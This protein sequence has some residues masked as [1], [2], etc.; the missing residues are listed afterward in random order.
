MRILVVVPPSQQAIDQANQMSGLFTGHEIQVAVTA[1]EQNRHLS[2]ADILLSNAFVPVTAEDLRGAKNLRFIQVLGVGVDHVDLAAAKAHGIV[3]ADVA[4]AN[5]TSVAEH[6]ILSLLCLYRPILSSHMAIQ[7]GQWPLAQWLNQAEDLTG[8]TI[9]IV[10]MGR[11]GRELARRLIPFAVGLVYNDV[12]RLP[13]E[14]ESELG[15][16]YVDKSDLLAISDAVTLHLP[17]TK[18]THHFMDREAF[19]LMQPGSVLVNA[20]RA[21]L[22]DQVALAEALQS[23]LRGAALDVFSPEPPNPGDPLLKLPN[24]LL[25]PHGAG[26]TKQ[27][28]EQIAK[29]ALQNVLRFVDGRSLEDV[30]VQP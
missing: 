2:E 6:V 13:E 22:V 16:S 10:G 25:T 23:H 20:A 7:N 18:E 29:R 9:G 11:I 21:E 8:K 19:R 14:A 1:E 4:G 15:V 28:Q 27:A 17:Y 12:V 26:T 3:V 30:V 24:V 5:S